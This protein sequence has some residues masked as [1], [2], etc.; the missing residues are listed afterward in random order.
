MGSRGGTLSLTLWAVSWEV[1][2]S[3]PCEDGRL[4]R[5]LEM[6]EHKQGGE[7]TVCSRHSAG[8][9]RNMGPGERGVRRPEHHPKAK[10][11]HR[12][13]FKVGSRCFSEKKEV[14]LDCFIN[15]S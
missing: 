1:S 3:Y 10:I 15:S 2:K 14:A 7:D 4:C 9:V 13:I 6:L 12:S 5:Q 8:C 11:H